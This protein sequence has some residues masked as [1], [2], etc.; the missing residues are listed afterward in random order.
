MWRHEPS[1]SNEFARDDGYSKED[2]PQR[3]TLSNLIYGVQEV[4]GYVASFVGLAVVVLMVFSGIGLAW[5]H[6]LHKLH[7]WEANG[8]EELWPSQFGYLD[9]HLQDTFIMVVFNEST[10]THREFLR[11]VVKVNKEVELGFK[12]LDCETHPAACTIGTLNLGHDRPV[13]DVDADE[14]EPSAIFYKQGV[15][16]ETYHA[17]LKADKN[18]LTV[19][20]RPSQGL[21]RVASLVE[22]AKGAADRSPAKLE[23]YNNKMRPAN[24]RFKPHGYRP[25]GAG[26]GYRGYPTEQYPD[27]MFDD[28]PNMDDFGGKDPSELQK[29]WMKKYDHNIDMEGADAEIDKRLAEE[30]RELKAQ[31]DA[32]FGTKDKEIR[33]D[34]DADPH[35]LLRKRNEPE[36]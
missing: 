17:H 23:A 3:S 33:E 16:T 30:E 35:G 20:A 25:H 14:D 6:A 32:A 28:M 9:L 1:A 24:G 2:K 8:L 18:V 21:E 36:A 19:A 26:P 5:N 12:I 27:D 31:A 13:P 34:A 11:D 10:P 22:W 7:G 29:E 15:P 4:F